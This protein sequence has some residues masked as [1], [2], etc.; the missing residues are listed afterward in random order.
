[1]WATTC[2][3]IVSTDIWQPGR[4]VRIE[5]AADEYGADEAQN[6]LY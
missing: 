1:M 6:N 4:P 3:Y 5:N 2:P